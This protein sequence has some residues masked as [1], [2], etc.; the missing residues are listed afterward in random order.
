MSRKRQT[1]IFD[2]RGS[3]TAQLTTL[4]YDYVDGHMVPEHFHHEDQV[5][6]ASRGVMTVQTPDGIWV[7]PPLR[8]IWIPGRT[9]HSILMSGAVLMRT[10]YFEHGF[11]RSAGKKCFVL[12]IS[13]LL[14]ELIIYACNQSDW[15][16]NIPSDRHLIDVIVDQLKIAASIPLQ[17]PQPKDARALRVVRAL[18]KDP[19]DPRTLEELSRSSGGGKRTI[20]RIFIEETSMTFGKWRQQLRLLHAMRLLASGEKVITAALEAGYQSPSAFISA[21]KKSLGETPNKYFENR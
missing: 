20:E 12:N 11:V 9:V 6:F 21:F 4:S 19:S 3:P 16:T 7:V 8:A 15:K 13:S 18:M 14:R 2:K 5:V 1:P 10:L 17:L